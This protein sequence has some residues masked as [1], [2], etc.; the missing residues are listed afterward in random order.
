[1][2]GAIEGT[3]AGFSY[4]YAVRV[5]IAE[6]EAYYL[7]QMSADGWE[8]T[9]HLSSETSMFGGPSIMLDFARNEEQVNIMLIFSTEENYTMVTLTMI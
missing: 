2:P 3:P 4:V 5:P 1:M 7:A 6:V 8:L 9:S